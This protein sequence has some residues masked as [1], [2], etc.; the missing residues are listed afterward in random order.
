MKKV[1]SILLVALCC[2]T[3][4]LLSKKIVLNDLAEPSHITVNGSQMYI[5][6]NG[7][8]VLYSLADFKQV[9]R[10]G[11]KGEGPGEYTNI[12]ALYL[13]PDYL[14]VSSTHKVIYFSRTGDFEKEIRIK[15]ML[16]Y[17]FYPVGNNF[18]GIYP[19]RTPGKKGYTKVISTYDQ[20]MKRL[21]P[22]AESPKSKK[23][24]TASGR[25]IY[26]PIP[27]Y[28]KHKVHGDLI[29]TGD[30]S[31]GMYFEIFNSNGKRINEIR[32]SYEIIK[33][34]KADKKEH[35]NEINRKKTAFRSLLKNA[36]IEFADDYPAFYDFNVSHNKIFAYTYKKKGEM[37]QIVSLN[38]N[39]KSLQ[40]TY[41]PVARVNTIANDTYYG[42]KDN[43]DSEEWELFIC[44][45]N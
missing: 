45:L 15:Q 1:L 42:L 41:V 39:G 43:A 21:T 36:K 19:K 35:L 22:L 33:I 13:L 29:F 9:K 3:V 30:S 24:S 11:G 27:H 14:V 5:A 12:I 38:F 20:N 16:G 44:R 18:V 25:L 26:N 6:D 40:S 10:F 28:F 23:A 37:M 34:T 17:F 8:I 31:K 4:P 32:A 2:A 7:R